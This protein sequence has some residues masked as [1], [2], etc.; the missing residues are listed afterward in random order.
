MGAGS[1]GWARGVRTSAWSAVAGLNRNSKAQIE[2]VRAVAIER[3]GRRVGFVPRGLVPQLD[4]AIR[5]HLAL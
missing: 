1:F 5:L 4:A 3:V 2:Q